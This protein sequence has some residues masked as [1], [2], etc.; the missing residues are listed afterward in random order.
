HK[1]G[2]DHF[3]GE[4]FRDHPR[5]LKGCNDLLVL[6]QPEI[7]KS[8]HRAYLEAGADILETN[9]FN[10]TSIS[11]GGDYG[12]GEYIFEINKRAA[13][14]ARQVADEVTAKTPEKP[15]LVAGSIGPTTKVASVVAEVGKPGSRSVS[16]DDLADSYAEQIAGLVAG[17]V[18]LL[19]P[20]T[21][22]DTLN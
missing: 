7:I 18:D 19:F 20:E 17:G 14:I 12:L 4:R 1:L 2:E 22:I 5:P 11:L 10:A 8:T 15:R 16:F 21:G 9:T 6:T 3:R 13:E